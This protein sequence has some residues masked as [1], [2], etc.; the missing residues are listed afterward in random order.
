M[1]KG[2]G[3]QRDFIQEAGTIPDG[4]E[5]R[6][7]IEAAASII[8]KNTDSSICNWNKKGELHMNYDALCLPSPL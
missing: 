7:E 1:K 6:I 8:V 4:A 3:C 5:T 2:H